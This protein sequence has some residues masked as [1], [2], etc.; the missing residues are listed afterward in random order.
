[1]HITILITLSLIGIIIMVGYNYL[2]KKNMIHAI[3]NEK[4]LKLPDLS[5][6]I[7]TYI[8]FCIITVFSILM[9][10]SANIFTKQAGCI[11]DVV[12][13]SIEYDLCKNEYKTIIFKN[14]KEALDNILYDYAD[15][16]DDIEHNRSKISTDRIDN[17]YFLL[18]N[19]RV[20]EDEKQLYTLLSIYHNYYESKYVELKIEKEK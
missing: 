14:Q 10:Q 5:D 20:S 4:V 9:N 8:I 18:E 3:K 11:S 2:F 19:N 1:M 6:V 15:L 16:I 12:I 17:I 13:E 7:V